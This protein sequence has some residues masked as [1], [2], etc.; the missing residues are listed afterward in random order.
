MSAVACRGQKRLLDSLELELQATVR[1][2]VGAG[3]Q[4]TAIVLNS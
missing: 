1:G 2:H 3:I 4:R